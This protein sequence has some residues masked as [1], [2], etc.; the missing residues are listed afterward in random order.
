MARKLSGYDR[1]AI[2]LTILGEDV[3][4]DILKNLD[5]QDIRLVGAAMAKVS[6]VSQEEIRS[7]LA[8]FSEQATGGG[9]GS[10]LGGRGYTQK[11]LTKALGVENAIR[12]MS[13]F[14]PAEEETGLNA[15]KW[16]EPKAVSVIIGEEHPQT[17]ALILTS[18]N[19]DQSS[20]VLASLPAALQ[21]DVMF[22]MATLEEIPPGV[23]KE[24][25]AGL[26]A[27]LSRTP[28]AAG[29]KVGGINLVA[30]I[31]NHMDQTSEKNTLESISEKN[32]DLA[33][34]IRRL[35]FVFDDLAQ[36]D[37]R[38]MQALLKEVSKEQLALALKAAKEEIK[39]KIY[40]NMSERAAELLKDDMETRGPVKLSDV[41]KTQQEIIKIAQRL[42]GE[43]KI[44]MG[45]KSEA[46]VLV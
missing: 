15:L 3:A 17:I 28:P 27:G 37:N 36:L 8:N 14:G 10:A 22:R 1:A 13:G 6:G 35:M 5:P 29:Q 18:L 7:V 40:K 2:L 32:P 12:V 39:E 19:P 43:G 33:E 34:R 26:Q 38:G 4:S 16:M 31:L 25:S 45:G 11:V 20:Q 30:G 24:V 42:A 46:D 41:E 44:M 23:M 9:S 21:S